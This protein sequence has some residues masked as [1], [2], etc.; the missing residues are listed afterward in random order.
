MKEVTKIILAEI[1][2]L[3]VEYKKSKNINIKSTNNGEFD[4]TVLYLNNL[5]YEALEELSYIINVRTSLIKE[6]VKMYTEVRSRE[7]ESNISFDSD[8]LTEDNKVMLNE[9]KVEIGQKYSRKMWMEFIVYGFL[10]V[11]ILAISMK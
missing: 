7:L 4:L 9:L 8:L 6:Y 10:L 5:D 11:L 1:K 3:L 2:K